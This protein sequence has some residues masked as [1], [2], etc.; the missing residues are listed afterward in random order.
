MKSVE[1]NGMAFGP[2]LAGQVIGRII[3]RNSKRAGTN[4]CRELGKQMAGFARAIKPLH[5]FGGGGT[6]ALWSFA[7]FAAIANSHQ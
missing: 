3:V 6:G 5:D 1:R 7:G 2:V 4:L